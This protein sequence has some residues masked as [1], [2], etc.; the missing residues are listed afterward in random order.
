MLGTTFYNFKLNSLFN[1]ENWTSLGLG[2]YDYIVV[3]ASFLVV[4]I[5]GA[6]EESGIDIRKSLEKKN[7]FIQ[8]ASIL[9]CMV[10]LIVFGIYR[11]DTISSDFIY[12]QF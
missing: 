9:I 10:V 6:I 1:F 3:F 12:K 8:F 4:L 2:T 11:G 5:F 7:A